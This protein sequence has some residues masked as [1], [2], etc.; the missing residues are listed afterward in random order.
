VLSEVSDSHRRLFV[1]LFVCLFA[2]C[3]RGDAIGGKLR[4]QWW[5]LLRCRKLS[6]HLLHC[7]RI[8]RPVLLLSIHNHHPSPFNSRSQ[9]PPDW[10][11]LVAAAE[12]CVLW[13]A[14]LPPVGDRLSAALSIS[15]SH[16]LQRD[17]SPLGRFSVCACCLALAW[18][19]T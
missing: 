5:W 9:D 13:L 7:P 12:L 8:H 11:L 16:F 6:V 1:C 3:A 19:L 4:L 14:S 17:E 15:P 2:L 10:N 18:V